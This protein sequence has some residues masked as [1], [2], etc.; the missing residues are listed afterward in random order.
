MGCH[1]ATAGRLHGHRSHG[2]LVTR[3]AIYLAFKHRLR[4]VYFTVQRLVDGPVMDRCNADKVGRNC[5]V[6]SCGTEGMRL[7]YRKIKSATYK[8]DLNT[9]PVSRVGTR[10]L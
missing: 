8:N 2:V 1:V 7:S 9:S 3:L 5:A 10:M 6:L 4:L